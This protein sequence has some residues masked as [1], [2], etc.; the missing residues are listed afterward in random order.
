[1]KFTSYRILSQHR[2]SKDH[3]GSSASQRFAPL[4][5]VGREREK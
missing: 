3:Y 2:G 5:D 4:R 1:M